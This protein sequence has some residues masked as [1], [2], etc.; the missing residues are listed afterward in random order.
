MGVLMAEVD[1]NYLNRHF[2][3]IGEKINRFEKTLNLRTK[4]FDEIVK[5]SLDTNY[6]I[7]KMIQE[8]VHSQNQKIASLQTHVNATSKI[9]SGKITSA[10]EENLGDSRD[11][12]AKVSNTV[13]KQEAKITAAAASIE[14]VAKEG[15]FETKQLSKHVKE[16]FERN[17][18]V[19]KDVQDSSESQSRIITSIQSKLEGLNKDI[20][21]RLRQTE[22]SVKS[23]IDETSKSLKMLQEDVYSMKRSTDVL[24][25][26][27]QMIQKNVHQEIQEIGENIRLDLEKNYGRFD[28][29]QSDI[30][31]LKEPFS[32]ID[33]HIGILGQK[34][35]LQRFFFIAVV[36]VTIASVTLSGYLFDRSSQA[37]FLDLQ[38]D[39][40]QFYSVSQSGNREVSK[41]L[42]MNTDMLVDSGKRTSEQIIK[43]I[44][45]KMDK[46][47]KNHL[48]KIRASNQKVINTLKE[49]NRKLLSI[50]GDQNEQQLR[51]IEMWLQ[52]KVDE[53]QEQS[54]LP[55]P[56]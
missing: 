33:E 20:D 27:V 35:R 47:T 15:E 24:I 1:N 30:A 29:L 19:L 21:Y 38:Q 11:L 53:N 39:L 50:I 46:I 10:I 51:V 22:N 44:E 16:A 54:A 48:G 13:E 5:E 40:Q 14:K 23:V 28:L 55:S 3:I 25:N 12:L 7:V 52:K 2:E 8:E 49:E 36:V 41:N 17:H 4:D 26:N 31:H 43:E 6:K 9:I 37:R 45:A 18:D 42:R 32:R 34:I 56:E